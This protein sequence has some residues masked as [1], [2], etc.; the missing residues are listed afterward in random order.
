M[1]GHESSDPC[2]PSDGRT[3]IAAPGGPKGCRASGFHDDNLIRGR[4]EV[5]LADLGLSRAATALRQ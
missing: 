5:S 1:T 4:A 3:R 2:R